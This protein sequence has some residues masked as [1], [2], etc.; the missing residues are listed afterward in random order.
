[1]AIVHSDVSSDSQWISLL[2]HHVEVVT[3]SNS[4]LPLLTLYVYQACHNHGQDSQD[5][6][7]LMGNHTERTP[8]MRDV[9][10][11]PIPRHD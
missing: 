2:E 10:S 1:M 6:P 5:P 9:R 3:A 4:H 7:A 8:V 11:E